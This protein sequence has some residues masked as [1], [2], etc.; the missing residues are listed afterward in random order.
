MRE[1]LLLLG[2]ELEIESSAGLGTTIF[3]RLPV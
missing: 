1:R 3:A 2:G